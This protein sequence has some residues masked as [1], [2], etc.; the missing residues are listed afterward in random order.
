MRSPVFVVSAAALAAV[1]A[2]QI[3]P[4]TVRAQSAPCVPLYR[5]RVDR[6]AVTRGPGGLTISGR[7]TNTGSRPLTYTQVVPTLTDGTGRV[8]FRGRG[9]LTASPLRPGRSAEF[10]AYEPSA[11][12][13]AAVRVT[14]REAGH[15]VAV[16]AAPR[17]ARLSRTF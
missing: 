8:V 7:V 17:P 13:F 6:Q 11:P 2:G 16:D 12:P 3:A 1:A 9:Y 14:L 4:P 15:P 5:V 10:R